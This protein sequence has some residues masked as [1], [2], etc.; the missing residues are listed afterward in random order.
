M[1]IFKYN[2]QEVVIFTQFIRMKYKQDEEEKEEK[3][4]EGRERVKFYKW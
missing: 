2:V 3:E 1:Y 4:E